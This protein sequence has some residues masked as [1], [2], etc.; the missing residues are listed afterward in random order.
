MLQKL[1]KRL[2]KKR[3]VVGVIL[4]VCLAGGWMVFG[5]KGGENGGMPVSVM[6]LQEK[7]LQQTVTL[8]APL[9]GTDTVEI[10]SNLHYE[11][12][13]LLVQEGDK[14]TK[15]QVLAVLDDEDMQKEIQSAQDNLELAQAQ[16]DNDLKNRQ[17]AYERA[18]QSL[19]T[20]QKQY[21]VEQVLYEAGG[22]SQAQFEQTEQALRQAQAEFALYQVQD[23]KVLPDPVSV[24]NLEIAQNT[25]NNK[26]ET[27]SNG[28]IISPIDG[29][30]TRVNIRVGR[31]ADETDDKKPMFVIENMEQLEMQVSVSEYDIAKIQEGQRVLVSADILNG[32]TV[33]GVVSRISPTGEEKGNSTERIIP[34]TIQITDTDTPLI[35]GINAKAQILIAEAKN[36]LTVPMEAVLQDEAGDSYVLKV[37]ENQILEKVIVTTG[38]ATDLEMEISSDQLQSG[39]QVVINPVG[40]EEGTT[41][42]VNV[43]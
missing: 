32:Q 22:V 10:V 5:Q 38:I 20:A 40:L 1:R 31:F 26:K 6:N 36:V 28:E 21:D 24:K 14:V 4:L 39:D 35:A 13:Q 27:L 7:D 43:V 37:N 41:V 30:V 19:D 11:V 3:V 16:Y 29:T 18:V 8:K 23:G 25:L 15:N 33:N 34:T 9:S 42:T 2:T 17:V 12:A